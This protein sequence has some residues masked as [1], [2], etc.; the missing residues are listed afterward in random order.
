MDLFHR[1]TDHLVAGN[2]FM[3]PEYVFRLVIAIYVA[4]NEID[5]N[6]AVDAMLDESIGPGSL[7]GCGPSDTKV[8]ADRFDGARGVVIELPIS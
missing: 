8:R 7:S 3:G 5:G 2:V 1:T 4:G 6:V